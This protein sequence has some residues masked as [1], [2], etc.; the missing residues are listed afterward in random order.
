MM[1]A[2]LFTLRNGIARSQ[3]EVL[4]QAAPGTI[5][6]VRPASTQQRTISGWVRKAD[7]EPEMVFPP[8]SLFVSTNGEGSHTYAYVS[9]F[10]FVPNSDVSVLIPKNDMSLEARIF[11]ARCITLNRPKFSFGRKPKGKRLETIE[12][13][14]VVPD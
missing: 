8:G 13:P 1:L 4:D 10:E 3:V 14:D 11:Y 6:F 5:P 12:L 2:D 9:R 7:L